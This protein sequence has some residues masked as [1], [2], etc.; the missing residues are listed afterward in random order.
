MNLD[1]VKLYETSQVK[2][3]IAGEHKRIDE[4]ILRSPVYS[5]K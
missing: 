2:F 5:W 1:T 4:S 3:K